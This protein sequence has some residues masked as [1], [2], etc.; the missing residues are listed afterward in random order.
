MRHVAHR[1]F[2]GRRHLEDAMRKKTQRQRQKPS[3]DALLKTRKKG[4]IQLTE[5][6][7]ENVTAGSKATTPFTDAVAGQLDTKIKF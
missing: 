5:K 1:K 7:L 3:P 2:V 6:D 4:E